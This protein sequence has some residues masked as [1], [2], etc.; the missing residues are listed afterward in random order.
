MHWLKFHRQ[1]MGSFNGRNL[2]DEGRGSAPKSPRDSKIHFI[3]NGALK[4]KIVIREK[5]IYGNPV[6]YPVC[7]VARRF[8]QLTDTKTLTPHALRVIQSLGYEITLERSDP[9]FLRRAI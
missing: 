2:P 8:T 4:M 3:N 7:S 9:D 5:H 6:Y 1:L